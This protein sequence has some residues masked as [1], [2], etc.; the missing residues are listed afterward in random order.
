VKH[1]A[2][3][4][5]S[6]RA[7][8]GPKPHDDDSVSLMDGVAGSRFEAGPVA[9]YL[10]EARRY[11][12]LSSSEEKRIARVFRRSR[13]EQASKAKGRKRISN[14]T[15]MRARS[16]LI[17]RNLRLVVAIARRYRNLGME[18]SDLI[19]EG[20]IGLIRAVERFDPDRDVRFSTYAT[21]WI[22]QAITRALYLRSRTVHV[23]INQTQL[24]QKAL[25]MAVELKARLG[26]TPDLPEIAH[27]V[28]IPVPRVKTALEAFNL[29][30]SLDAPAVADGSPRW[31][32][33]ADPR[34]LS[35]LQATLERERR[36][37]VKA[38]V[39]TLSPRQQLVMRMRFAIDSARVY[40][41]EEIGERLD[42][43]R[44]RVRQ[45]ENEALERLRRE[46]KKRGL[47][48]LAVA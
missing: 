29:V 23:P 17:E 3:R 38:L 47:E 44:E 34:A 36:D 32:L 9:L 20:N 31:Q 16:T 11:P 25:R 35:P 48:R 1:A 41:L 39:S 15:A 12:L 27:E 7:R 6:L 21:W 10:S 13:N 40:T 18:L 2:G 28:G 22:R 4:S 14:R 43:T 24:A 30:D 19:Q 37:H 5:S 46:G 33:E 26:R 42:L 45:I 8:L